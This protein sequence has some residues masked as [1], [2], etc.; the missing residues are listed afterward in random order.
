VRFA[1]GNGASR[2]VADWSVGLKPF[3]SVDQLLAAL[4]GIDG[5]PT[6]DVVAA[7]P[8]LLQTAELLERTHPD[9]DELIVAGLVHDLASA[10]Q[11]GCPDHA[12]AGA[13]LVAP[14]LGDR[15]A[16]LVAGHADAKRYLVTVEP[17]Y[18]GQLSVN[19]TATLVGQGGSMSRPEVERFAARSECPALVALRRADDAAKVPGLVTRPLAVWRPVLDRVA[20]R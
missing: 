14:V 16:E 20:G 9:D 19:S 15:V 18:A 12:D 8:H 11:I 6:D 17:G 5:R 2:D 1:S 13:R 7:L 4:H 3:G 10:L